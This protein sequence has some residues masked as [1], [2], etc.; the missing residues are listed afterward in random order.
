MSNPKIVSYPNMVG[1][2]TPVEVTI[3]E[4]PFD[5]NYKYY[6]PKDPVIFAEREDARLAFERHQ[7]N[8]FVHPYTC[9]VDSRHENLVMR[10]TYQ[11]KRILVC[12]TCGYVQEL[13]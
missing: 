2:T 11:G 1:G 4:I 12:P 9:G 13:I 8:P 5:T 7:N 3:R 10:F 6:G